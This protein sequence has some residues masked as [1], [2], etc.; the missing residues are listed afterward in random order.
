MIKLNDMSWEELAIDANKRVEL[1]TQ[2]FDK[3]QE[4]IYELEADID[5]LKTIIEY[6]EVKLGINNSI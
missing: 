2:H 3:M 5:Q 1:A 4:Q 6:L